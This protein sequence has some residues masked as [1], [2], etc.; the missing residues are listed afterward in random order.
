M[1]EIVD[2][3]VWGAAKRSVSRYPW[4]EWCDGRTWVLVRGEDFSCQV[5]SMQNTVNVH[6]F[7]AAIQIRTRILDDD[8]LQIKAEVHG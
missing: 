2:D 1:A 6:A 4:E 7:R 5:K 3:A 8:R